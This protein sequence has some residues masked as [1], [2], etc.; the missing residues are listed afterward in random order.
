MSRTFLSCTH[1]K[2][3]NRYRTAGRLISCIAPR[4]PL[5]GGVGRGVTRL[6][7]GR[8]S[9]YLQYRVC[10]VLSAYI[11]LMPLIL[12]DMGDLSASKMEVSAEGVSRSSR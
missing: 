10:C 8:G 3:V 9:V 11:I 12:V 7:L 5:K 2:V 1:Q 4:R 6:N